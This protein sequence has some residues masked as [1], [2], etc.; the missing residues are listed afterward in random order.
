MDEKDNLGGVS[1]DVGNHLIDH[2]TDDALLKPR[3][4]SR[5]GPD[6][7]QIISQGCE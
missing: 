1:V 7:F 6:N 5:G 2:S 3:I 4:R